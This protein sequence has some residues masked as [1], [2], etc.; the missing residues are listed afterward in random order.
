[1][2]IHSL[3]RPSVSDAFVRVTKSGVVRF[4]F[5]FASALTSSG[6]L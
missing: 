1:M 3:T 5:L 4:F 2:Y 6:W